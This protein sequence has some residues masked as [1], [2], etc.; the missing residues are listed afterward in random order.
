MRGIPWAIF[1]PSTLCRSYTHRGSTLR[2][3]IHK[4]FDVGA[5]N[6]PLLAIKLCQ[7]EMA[8]QHRTLGCQQGYPQRSG[9]SSTF[10]QIGEPL[11]IPGLD[12]TQMIGGLN[13]ARNK[14]R[15]SRRAVSVLVER[16]RY[17]RSYSRLW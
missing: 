17:M 9:R 4:R 8:E 13:E 12:R 3:A 6:F 7:S 1:E 5:Q 11:S 15:R 2:R 16:N 14:R 10:K